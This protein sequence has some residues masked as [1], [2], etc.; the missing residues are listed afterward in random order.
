[1]KP[2]D[3]TQL[4]RALTK[5]ERLRQGPDAEIMR[6]MARELARKFPLRM[7]SRSGQRV[8]FVEL[9]SVTHFYAKD[10]LTFAATASKDYVI[11][12]SIAE[13]EHKLDPGQ[14]LR[15]HR[16]TLLNLAFVD[17]VTS[18][19]GAGLVVRLKDGK[20]TELPVA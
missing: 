15:I 18:W 16:S 13:L 4:E 11:D 5:L 2:I 14:F 20:R 9:A 19:F 7:A 17:E 10:K 12:G 1:L 6:A 8:V 3:A